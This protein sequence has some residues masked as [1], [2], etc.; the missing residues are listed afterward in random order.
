MVESIRKR[1][2]EMLADAEKSYANAEYLV[3]ITYPVVKDSKLLLRAL[4]A[5]Y[6]SV[7]TAISAIL[8]F[9]FLYKRIELTK[10]SVRNQEVFF[11]DCAARYGISEAD[12]VNIKA[13]FEYSLKHKAS[14]TE[15]ARPGK[16]MIMDDYMLGTDLSVN[17]LKE[18][19]AVVKRLLENATEVFEV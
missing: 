15:L 14:G 12:K 11:R 1:F 8:Y 7:V 3:R 17:R 19:L 13:I 18:L 10:D 5:L 9:E 4:E 2:F 16:I 6:R